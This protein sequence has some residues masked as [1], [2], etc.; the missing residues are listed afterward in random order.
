MVCVLITLPGFLTANSSAAM[1]TAGQASAAPG[2]AADSSGW[3][4][5][6]SG[7]YT[8]G[9]VLTTL[10]ADGFCRVSLPRDFYELS[11]PLSVY[12]NDFNSAFSALSLQAKADGWLLSVSGKKGKR[13][14]S[15]RLDV[16]STASYISCLDT[17]VRSVP[18]KDLYRFRLSDSL[19]CLSRTRVRDSLFALRDSLLL[20]SA[21][22]RVSFYVVSSA[23]VRSLGVSW[24]EIFA[25]GDLVSVPDFIT[26]WTFRA[27]EANDTTAEF[28]SVELDV[29]SSSYLHWGSQ[30]K[31][32]DETIL[33][34]TGVSKSSYV[35]RDYGLTLRLSRDVKYGIRGEYTLAQ[36]DDQNSVLKG[37]FGGGGK[38]SI[39]AYGVFDSYQNSTDGIPWLSNIP[40]IGYLF[41]SGRREKIKQF[42]V[43]EI[44]RLDMVSEV[45]RLLPLDSVKVREW[46]LWPDSSAVDSSGLTENDNVS[47]TEN[48]NKE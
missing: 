34:S 22:Y 30:K 15:A 26:D 28:R 3:A 12:E 33:T 45:K 24:T 47:L 14:V 43:I 35:W 11:V 17:S 37:N 40:L 42:F 13:T 6:F 20:P 44:V 8:W 7:V 31:E 19:R 1:P 41:G 16:E 25:K 38:D 36:R 18:S 23:F 29:D 27:V 9:E 32:E 10:C 5:E 46:D 39:T 21:R 4:Y 48:D 2:G